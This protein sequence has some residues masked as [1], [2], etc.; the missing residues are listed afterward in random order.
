MEDTDK[1]EGCKKHLRLHKFLL[2]IHPKLQS[3][4][5]TIVQTKRQEKLEV[6][7]GTPKGV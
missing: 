3:Y 4:G 1:S 6:G 7:R 5:K 2:K